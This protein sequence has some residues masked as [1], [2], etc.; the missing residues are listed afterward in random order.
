MHKLTDLFCLTILSAKFNFLAS[1]ILHFILHILFSRWCPLI[2]EFTV[3]LYYNR[4]SQIINLGSKY[5]LPSARVLKR[6]LKDRVKQLILTKIKFLSLKKLNLFTFEKMENH[7]KQLWLVNRCIIFFRRKL[8]DT[9]LK[10][11]QYF[12]TVVS[13]W[14]P[15]EAYSRWECESKINFKTLLWVFRT[16]MDNLYQY[17]YISI[18]EQ[19][20]YILYLILRFILNKLY[21]CF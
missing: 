13:A 5:N 14:N 12:F 15:E 1:F 17:C 21:L 9:K 6:P 11:F 16:V 4:V 2:I 18:S 7:I 20:C 19:Y 10:I 8:E 3:K